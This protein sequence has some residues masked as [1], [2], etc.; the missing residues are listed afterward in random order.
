LHVSFADG[1]QNLTGE[2]SSRIEELLSDAVRF[3]E[4]G[5]F[6]RAQALYRRV[7]DRQANRSE[8]FNGLGLLAL[9][10]ARPL[11]ALN[12][13]ELA[14]GVA[15][16]NADYHFNLSRVY[17]ALGRVD[18]A[19]AAGETALSVQSSGNAHCRMGQLY[20]EHG[21]GE[22]AVAAFK[23]A[24]ELQPD[25]ASTCN[26]LGSALERVARH[27]EAVDAYRRAL[28]LKPDYAEAANNLG[29]VL[30]S[31]GTADEALCA[32]KLAAELSPGVAGVHT[33]I[34]N[35]YQRKGQLACAIAAYT[36]ALECDPQ[37]LSARY[38]LAT[39]HLGLADVRAAVREVGLCLERAPHDQNALALKG[40]LLR[41]LGHDDEV[42][43]LVDLERFVH[44]EQL[45][46]PTGYR[47]IGHFNRELRRY[48]VE[49]QS[50]LRD[51]AGASTRG[52]RHS[53]DIFSRPE[54]PAIALRTSLQRVFRGFLD[55]LPLGSSHPFLSR[56]PN[57]LRLRAQA[58]ILDNAGFL[59]PHIHPQA[60]VSGVYYV[61]V[62]PEIRGN[63]PRHAGWLEL[64][65]APETLR[66]TAK[67]EIR[68]VRPEE[69]SVV[70]FPSY[71][72]HGT[73]PFKSKKHRF[74]LGLDAIIDS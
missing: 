71:Y 68:H 26:Q 48:V 11:E 14:I 45:E 28:E 21:R 27:P 54:G 15:P 7:L 24:V 65:R 47:S 19:I 44:V 53:G 66:S 30:Q 9:H 67:P 13:F 31:T 59:V 10:Q 18:D 60:W 72:Y 62:P 69:G 39:A 55:S 50:L 12:L 33:N 51:P 61:R 1:A 34:G 56:T 74:S 25:C 23:R 70:L 42:R 37:L 6:S 41:E 64:G 49:T 57:G 17:L 22:N 52:G 40:V 20:L 38:L 2:G 63:D 8:A 16:R 35:V 5:D 43:R 4:D 3:H 36:Q 29:N 58:N 73:I 32:Y 46:P